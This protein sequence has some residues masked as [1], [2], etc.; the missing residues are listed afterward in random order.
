MPRS[1][2]KKLLHSLAPASLLAPLPPPGDQGFFL[3]HRLRDLML[4]EG[5]SF[6]KLAASSGLS[7][8]ELNGLGSGEITPTIQVLW[9]IANALG[10][11]F[12]SVI[13]NNPISNQRHQE[14]HVLRDS[15]KKLISSSN[16]RFTSRPLFPFDSNRL[17]EFYEVTIASGHLENAEAHAAGTIESLVVVSGLVEINS[18][19]E[20]PQRLS[21]GDA[22]VFESD[23][24]HSYQN[25]GASEALLHL[26]ISYVNLIDL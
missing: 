14:M 25:L 22:I 3:G 20:P 5:V 7:H 24:P 23:V 4:R 12:G 21:R 9:K 19:K 10:V 18:G 8:E 15:E 26:L 13:P 11:P 17:V 6:E 2:S 16:G 1:G